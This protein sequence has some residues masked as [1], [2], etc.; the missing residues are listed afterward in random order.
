MSIIKNKK[1]LFA[2]TFVF[3]FLSFFYI[4]FPNE[5]LK[6]RVI[7]E[8]EKNTD[9]DAEIEK[10]SI[11]PLLK[12]E[13]S[14]L[15]L[16]KNEDQQII[17]SKAILKPSILSLLSGDIN[18][19]YDIKVFKGKA[20]GNLV[21]LKDT[22][23]LKS[24]SLNI[25]KIDIDEIRRVYSKSLKESVELA[26]LLS[27]NI[28]LGENNSG[29]FNFNIDDL[30]I[31][32]IDINNFK[33]QLM[34]LKSNLKGQ[35]YKDKTLINELMFDNEDIRVKIKGS[36]P[37]LWRLSKGSIDLFYR[38]EV[39]GKK[40]AYLKSFL[41][42]DPRGNVAGK[43][44]GSLAKPELLKNVNDRDVKQRRNKTHR[45]RKTFSSKQQAI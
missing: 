27:G 4:E 12:I 15:K 10:I 14:G 36:T 18:V 17:V 25:E 3:V 38:L 23:N 44:V 7:F 33:F 22:N 20:F 37:P 35:I 5:S 29:D 31:I 21:I 19:E 16:T 43:I 42:K 8:I 2:I 34:D 41:S 40:Y 32:K 11:M 9:F 24:I 28:T 30:D 45:Y 6:R 39:K 13:I 26:G 1:I